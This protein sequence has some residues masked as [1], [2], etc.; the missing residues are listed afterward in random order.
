MCVCYI[1]PNYFPVEQ[2]LF[3]KSEEL[4][5]APSDTLVKIATFL[6]IDPHYLN[7]NEKMHVGS[8]NSAQTQ[9]EREYLRG[10]YHVGVRELE[11]LLGWNCSDWLV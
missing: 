2:T 1:I 6:D 3:L 10:I 8:Y 4:R 5:D 9:D 11:E 7:I